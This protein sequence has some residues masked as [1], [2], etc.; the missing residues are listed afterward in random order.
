MVTDAFSRKIL[1]YAVA[2]HME[3][4]SMIKALKM[5]TAFKQNNLISTIHHS[6]RGIQYCSNQYTD[7]LKELGVRCWTLMSCPEIG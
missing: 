5:A 3:T 7:Q 1:G 2:D 4:E 6:D